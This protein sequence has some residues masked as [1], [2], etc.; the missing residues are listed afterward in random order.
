MSGRWRDTHPDE[1]QS[2][3]RDIDIPWALAGGWALDLWAGAQSR[4]HSDIEIAIVRRDLPRVLVRLSA[5]EIAI[6]QNK[7][8]TAF[9]PGAV[10]PSGPFSCWLRRHG[11]SLWDFEIVAETELEGEWAY[12]RMPSVRRHWS[13]IFVPGPGMCLVSPAV[14]LLYKCGTPRPKDMQDLQNF[15]HRLPA[16]ELGW[17]LSAVAIA[18]PEFGD[19]LAE[20]AGRPI[21]WSPAR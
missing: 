18:H 2:W 14:Q 16:P 7:Q 11:N 9:Q 8:L 5:F 13:D 12:R 6:A 1:L 10:L 3:L 21:P 17:L 4:E 20:I 19:T 15:V